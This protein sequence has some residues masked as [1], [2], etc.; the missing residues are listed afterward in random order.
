MDNQ[1]NKNNDP[2]NNR[3]G[4]GIIL[5]TTL[6]VAF[7]VMGLYSLMQ[8]TGPEEISY[9]KFLKLVDG[10]EVEEVTLSSTR[11]YITLKDDAG[12]DDAGKDDAKD[13][14]DTADGSTDTAEDTAD[15]SGNAA[16]TSENTGDAA[17][18]AADTSENAGDTDTA[19]DAAGTSEDTGDTAGNAADTA[20]DTA[21]AADGDSAE[22]D[23]GADS[24]ISQ[25]EQE[26]RRGGRE[27]DPD[28]YTGVVSDDTLAQRLEEN[29]VTFGAE[30]PDTV[31]SL[32]FEIFVTVIL[33][34]VLLVILFNFLMKKMTKGGG[35]MGIGKSNAKMYMEKETGVTF[36]DVAGEDEA[37]ESLQEVVDFLHNPGKY[38][39][40]GAKLPKGALL[41]GPPGTGK[42]LLAK[43]VAGEAKVPFF[44]LS[45]SAFV[46][47]YVGVGASRV[48][49]LF[50]QAQQQAPCIVFI[51]EIDAI[52]KTRDTAMG[53]NDEREQ[54]L[55]QLLAEMDGFDTNKGLLILAATNRPEI[56]DPA[57]LRPG[58]FDRR[59]IV[60][61]PDLKG[62]IDILKVHAKD[63]RMDD[64]VDLEAIALATSGAVGSDLA[65]MINEAAIN[66]VKH[67]R[68]VVSQKDLFEAV[69]VVLVGKEKKDRIMSKEER[70]IVSYHEVGHALVTALQKN[71]EP[72]QKITI[73]P[74]TMGALGYVMQT[75]EEEKFLNTKK[76]LEAMIVV[77]LGGRA[78]EEI[79]FDTV[80]TG[81][82]NDI[83]QATKIARAMITQYGMSE[84]FGLMGLESIQNRYLDGR[85]VMNCGEATASEI[86][87]EV[88]RMLKAAYEEAKKLLNENREALDKIAA[89]LIEKETI[90]GKE[91]MKIFR[92]VKGIPE[93]ESDEENEARREER[94]AMKPVES[95]AEAAVEETA[96]S[97]KLSEE[98]CADAETDAEQSADPDENA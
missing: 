13:A 30:V 77:A 50:K 54:T 64:S 56:L 6:L 10:G 63:V 61:K 91:F 44:S 21:D 97:E 93:P 1:N 62:R 45:G 5:V 26:A 19:G 57:L 40:I 88:M 43:A 15:A 76:E 90:T 27:K 53:G 4:W 47:M 65:N 58:R 98:E 49:D 95:A 83:E 68:Q 42:T 23:S 51:D 14:G 71:T 11:I 73:V 78:A 60:D 41:V 33:P 17:G 8:G 9:D 34:I 37:K 32:F 75:P 2:N 16:D 79:V 74:R 52:G 55:N 35:M 85:A 84:R 59:I 20:E 92:E 48:R 24:I 25:I 82:S 3:Q 31:G 18:N 66:A 67:G 81:A 86:D 29:G 94:I 7:V 96:G 28:Y 22:Q 69:E 12:K 46:E 72:V 70:R 36:Q 38:S 39:G 89:F 80:T 87:E